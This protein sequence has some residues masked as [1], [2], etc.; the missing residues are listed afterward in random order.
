M[1]RPRFDRLDPAKKTLILQT[2]ARQFAAHG[3]HDAS[4]NQ[5][6]GSAGI[7]K[8]AAYYYFDDKADLFATVIDRYI[9]ET[10]FGPG[11]ELMREATART[12]WP[13]VERIYRAMI[14]HTVHEP[15]LLA[16]W[17]AVW[18]LP[19]ELRTS[20]P[21]ARS[22]DR[23]REWSRVLLIRGRA[24]G[25]VRADLPD[26]LLVALMFAMD[27]AADRWLADHWDELGPQGLEA[28]MLMSVDLLKRLL[29]P[30]RKA[31]K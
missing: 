16:L 9:D 21:L 17:R 18:K 5:I 7:S 28:T 29:E 3:F 20:G 12:F 23:V 1:P 14:E 8:G 31:R 22:F 27:E 11:E 2:A 10:L 26:D 30:P 15:W 6:L 24:L 4:L 25:V 13:R 19:V